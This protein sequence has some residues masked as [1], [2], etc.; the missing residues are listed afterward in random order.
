M[1]SIASPMTKIAR[2]VCRQCHL[3][4]AAPIVVNGQCQNAQACRV[5]CNASELRRMARQ[6]RAKEKKA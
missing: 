1:K 2:A 4:A 6:H 5:R 3:R